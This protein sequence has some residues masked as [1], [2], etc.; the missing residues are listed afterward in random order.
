M[1]DWK[2]YFDHIYC[3]HY[4]P[5][6]DRYE[7]CLAELE[8]TG[9]RKSGVFSWKLTWDSP[10]F[11]KLY[12]AYPAAPS[13]G[14]MKIGFAH[15]MCIKEAY[16]LGFNNVLILE[17]DDIFLKDLDR[18]EKILENTPNCDIIFYDKIPAMNANYEAAV[19]KDKIND[20]FIDIGKNFYVLANCYALN[21]RGMEHVLKNQERNLQVSDYYLKYVKNAIETP[22]LTRCAAIT[23]IAIQN[24]AF[25]KESENAKLSSTRKGINSNID[26]YKRLGINFEDYNR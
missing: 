2:K 12:E 10:I 3:I 23:P 25:E 16:E 22:G 13:V 19:V 15:Y 20:D 11:N 6:G 5:Y 21:R 24:P 7:K 26:D 9:I 17:N 8:R 14:C 18:M 1:I 4:M